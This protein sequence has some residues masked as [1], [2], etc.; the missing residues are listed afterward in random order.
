MHCTHTSDPFAR[1]VIN[2]RLHVRHGWAVLPQPTREHGGLVP[3]LPGFCA[4]LEIGAA[5]DMDAP[6]AERLATLLAACD[7]F[8]VIGDDRDGVMNVMR[9][10]ET[11]LIPWEAS[12]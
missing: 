12:A 11:A 2:Y 4:K 8:H 5:R 3:P 6:T 9:A 1:P 7:S 10:I